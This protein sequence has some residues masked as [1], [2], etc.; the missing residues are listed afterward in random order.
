MGPAVH[1][2]F[3]PCEFPPISDQSRQDP[4]CLGT[5]ARG[6]YCTPPEE[7]KVEP[8]LG[9]ITLGH[10]CDGDDLCTDSLDEGFHLFG[11]E[12]DNMFDVPE[13]EERLQFV[14]NAPENLMDA[15]GD[16]IWRE[17]HPRP[18]GETIGTL[19]D[20][21]MREL[22]RATS[23]VEIVSAFPETVYAT[24]H[25]DTVVAYLDAAHMFDPTG[26]GVNRDF[27]KATIKK[28]G[29]RVRVHSKRKSAANTTPRRTMISNYIA[30]L[31]KAAHGVRGQAL[32]YRSALTSLITSLR[33]Q[34]DTTTLPPSVVHFIENAEAAVRQ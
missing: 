23:P 24:K 19:S 3:H 33:Q 15:K 34:V 22:S 29:E 21:V 1:I 2:A 28:I 20:N 14:P 7:E 31:N 5:V 13:P 17:F 27:R 26:E 16:I 6:G 25:K 11:P 10:L 4:P 30:D 12:D 32:N 8:P 18:D 9:E